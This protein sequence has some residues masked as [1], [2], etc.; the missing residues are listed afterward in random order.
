MS[1]PFC[2]SN[3]AVVVNSKTVP[4]GKSGAKGP[5]KVPIKSLTTQSQERAHRT[6]SDTSV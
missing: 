1:L 2:Q 5:T 3:G 6:L 4:K